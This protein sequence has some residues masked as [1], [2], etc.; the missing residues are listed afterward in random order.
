[1]SSERR[2]TEP[3]NYEAK[4]TQDI[5]P[6]LRWSLTLS[7][8]AMLAFAGLTFAQ[9]LPFPNLIGYLFIAIAAVDLLIA[10]VVFGK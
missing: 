10:F 1:M 8:V 3:L 2:Q 9:V 7:S 5:K 6:V 4:K